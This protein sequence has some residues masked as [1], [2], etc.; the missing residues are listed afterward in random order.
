MVKEN[1]A[2]KGL[3]RSLF[4]PHFDILMN[5]FLSDTKLHILS[6]FC[7]GFVLDK[8]DRS[9]TRSDPYFKQLFR[10]CGLHLYITKVEFLSVFL[11]LKTVSGNCWF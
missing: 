8:E 7:A 1:L 10:R 3:F 5:F 2:K 11:Y 4:H 9:I 6:F